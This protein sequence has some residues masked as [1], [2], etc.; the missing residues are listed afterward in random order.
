MEQGTAGR[1]LQ[2]T[3]RPGV[4]PVGEQVRIESRLTRHC[5]HRTGRRVDS[6]N[7]SVLPTEGCFRYPLQPCV[8]G[9]VQVLPG[10]RIVT[11]QN[12]KDP[13]PGVRLDAL[14]PRLAV[15]PILVGFLDTCLADVRCSPIVDP[16]DSIEFALTDAADIADDMDA[17]RSERVV[18]D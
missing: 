7:R 8:H 12:P 9:E 13:S 17:E 11:L 4:D 10:N 3:I 6:D 18:P 1:T 5:E 2:G 16:I 14:V 15:Q